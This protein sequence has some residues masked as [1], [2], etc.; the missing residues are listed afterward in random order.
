MPYHRVHLPMVGKGWT[1]RVPP[2]GV[3][4]YGALN[5]SQGLDEIA[6][7]GA[8]WIRLPASWQS[9]EP[10]DTS[11][12]DY[13]W[14]G[15]DS[16]VSNATDEGI[17]LILT[18][19]DQPSWAAV[20]GM[21]PVTNTA[22]IQEF[23][24][25]MVE[26]Y[27][28]DGVD[29]ALGSPEVTHF[30]L[31]NEPDNGDLGHALHGGWGCFGDYDNDVPGC[32]DAE[33][34]ASLLQSLYPVVKDADPHAKLVFGGMALDWFAPDG[35]FD[36][37]FLPNV[38]SACQ[39]RDCFDVMNFHYYPPFRA[40]WEPNGTGIIGKATY[41]RQELAAYGFSDA[42]V[43]CTETSWAAG[44]AWGSDELQSRYAVKAY[45][46]GMAADLDVVTWFWARDGGS[47]GRP[48]L[49]DDDVQPKDSYWSF[50][51]MAAM[52]GSAIYERELTLAETGDE[53]IEGYVF[54][55]GGRLDVVWTEDDTRYVAEDDPVLP[56]AVAAVS[57]RVTDK[58]GTVTEYRDRDDGDADGEIT[59]QVGGSPLFLEYD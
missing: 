36:R 6:D 22:D 12:E 45:V 39:G 27:D 16:D 8:R 21:G 38:L 58:F 33:D 46:R 15:L 24:G 28:A 35:P 9:I 57:L 3:Q 4:F 49:L 11:P 47:D 13:R 7:A 43:I 25:A 54:R 1:N 59:V 29:D 30:E 5:D 23:F 48:G 37:D 2:F 44:A 56:L 52:L 17:R 55:R 53:L 19:T 20:F 34:Y 40:R 18:L 10:T 26:R 42:P 51:T 14:S 41:V 50:Q 31:Y 32:G